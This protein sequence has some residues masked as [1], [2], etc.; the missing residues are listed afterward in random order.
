MGYRVL[1]QNEWILDSTK[2]IVART[3]SLEDMEQIRVW[4]N[5][6]TSVLR[7]SYEISVEQQEAYFQESILPDQRSSSPVNI[8]FT[9]WYEGELFGYGGLVHVKWDRGEAEISFLIRPDWNQLEIFPR[10]FLLFQEFLA[11]LC[12]RNLGLSTI[13]AETFDVFERRLIITLLEQSGFEL[14]GTMNG[15]YLKGGAPIRSLNH[16]KALKQSEDSL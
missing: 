2:E 6:Q 5:A 3:I 12:T 10:A 11:E 8:L 1:D 14:V 9:L 16:R 7:Q 4:R 13:T 15:N